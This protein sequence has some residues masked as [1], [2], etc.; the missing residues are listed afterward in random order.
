MSKFTF[1]YSASLNGAV[2]RAF[3]TTS[4]YSI[5][6]AKFSRWANMHNNNVYLHNVSSHKI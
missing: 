4:R 1:E 6:F 2:K 5:A 3:V